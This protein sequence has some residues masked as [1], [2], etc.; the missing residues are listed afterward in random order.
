MHKHENDQPLVEKSKAHS[1]I[2]AHSVKA[3]QIKKSKGEHV[4]CYDKAIPLLRE[5]ERERWRTCER[6]W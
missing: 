2:P 5:R 6:I 4:H 1:N 3:V